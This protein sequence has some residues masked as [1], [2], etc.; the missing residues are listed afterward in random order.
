[1]NMFHS[2]V[3]YSWD[4]DQLTPSQFFRGKLPYPP[5]SDSLP[6]GVGL[7]N[8]VMEIIKNV[9]DGVILFHGGDRLVIPSQVFGEAFTFHRSPYHSQSGWHY[10]EYL[11]PRY[12][13][14]FKNC[15]LTC[16]CHK[17]LCSIIS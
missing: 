12:L 5:Q 14:L 6:S 13:I 16:F 8:I 1:M 11:N 2:V 3:T 17:L 4:H 10:H 9:F 15:I 7:L